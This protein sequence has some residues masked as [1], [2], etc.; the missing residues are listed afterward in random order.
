MHEKAVRGDLIRLRTK[1]RPVRCG[2]GVSLA[3]VC[4]VSRYS[5]DET[6][7][8]TSISGIQNR[9]TRGATQQDRFSMSRAELRAQ[10][11]V[12]HKE[13]GARGRPP[14]SLSYLSLSMYFSKTCCLSTS[15][16]PSEAHCCMTSWHLGRGLEARE[17]RGH[18][19]HDVVVQ[20][21]RV[22]GR[23]YLAVIGCV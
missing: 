6:E 23:E 22:P 12:Y 7:E 13:P 9:Q 4:F 16:S 15:R 5:R 11:A 18:A 19:R 10:A 3:K 21:P 20:E 1:G 8:K 2:R 14:R 17:V